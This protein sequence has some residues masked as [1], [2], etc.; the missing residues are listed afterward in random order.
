MSNSNHVSNVEQRHRKWSLSGVCLLY[1]FDTGVAQVDIVG[2]PV[3][4]TDA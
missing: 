3:D 2:N 1:R 4:S